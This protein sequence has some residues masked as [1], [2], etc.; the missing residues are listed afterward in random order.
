[1]K[2][3]L[4]ITTIFLSSLMMASV[5]NAKWT[6]VVKSVNENTYYV[7]L[8]RIKK[9]NGKIYFWKLADYLKP[10]KYGAISTKS[11][12][13]AEC[14]R[15]RIRYLNFTTYKGPMASGE[16]S[17]SNNT[18]DKD[19]HYPPPDSMFEGVLKAVCNYKP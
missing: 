5:A 15:L 4:I 10:D 3:L 2:P 1:M 12:I 13:E 16:V 11:Y 9:H 14:S 19:W 18:P 6:E 7:D 17:T 8:E